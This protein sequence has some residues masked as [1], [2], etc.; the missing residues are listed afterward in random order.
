MRFTIR[1]AKSAKSATSAVA[2]FTAL[3]ITLSAAPAFARQA[4]V[5]NAP[6]DVDTYVSDVMRAFEVPGIALAIV[7]D[8]HVV[9]A[10]GYGVKE[11]GKPA[12]VD[13]DTKFGIASNTKLFTATA[14]GMLVEAGKLAWDRPVID[15]MPSFRLSDPYVTSQLTVR[16]LLVHRSGLGL[17]AGDLL[18]WP[19]SSYSRKDLVNRLRFIPLSTSFRSA[20]AYDNVLYAVAG[21]LVEAVSGETWE[22][23]VKNRIIDRI[24]MTKTAVRY[25]DAIAM[26]NIAT[27]HAPVDGKVQVVPAY[28]NDNSN[29]AASIMTGANDIAKWM[30]VQ[31]DSGRIEGATQRLFGA[32]T[33]R[34]LWTLVTPINIGTPPPELA[35][36]RMNFNGYALG[37]GVR[38][39]RG[40][41][42]LQHTGG[43]PGYV[44]RVFMIPELKLGVAILTNQ[45]SGAAFDA[46]GWH[47]LDYYSGAPAF[48]WL[49]GY[50][51]VNA[52]NR[53]SI[54]T[55]VQTARAARDSLSKPSLPL[56]QYAGTYTDQWY[57]N[58]VIEQGPSG[59]V[60][61][62]GETASLVG[63]LVHWQHDTF[64]VRWRD[65]SLRADAY[66]TFALNPNGT[67][68]DLKMAPASPEVDFSFDFQ[69]LTLVKTGH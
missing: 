62:F 16:D 40:Y 35:P 68:R 11:L 69:D 34:Q 48:D 37:V 7:K 19:S 10:R 46:I 53:A 63:D 42:L 50:I 20:Y 33:A 14:L 65:R 56:A 57:G 29:P 45:E 15:Y 64:L 41:K 18:W 9:V 25:A 32:A 51:K 12:L 30:I 1:R 5:T 67:I 39:Y 3:F 47:V 38:D 17:G 27:T 44:S 28:A 4:P 8:G 26:G 13:A 23:F 60:M 22:S 31:M 24:G 58:V 2:L 6:P 43:L 59:L 49:G 61:R 66:A 52:R 21:E 55:A 36:Q 54:T